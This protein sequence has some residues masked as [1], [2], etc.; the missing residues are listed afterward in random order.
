MKRLTTLGLAFVLLCACDKETFFAGPNQYQDGFEDYASL[1]DLL[2]QNELLWSFNQLTRAGNSI[3]VD[4]T[5]AHE[6]RKSLKF[7]AGKSADGVV[8]K[9][10]VAK[11]NMAF[12]E[13]E[14]MRMSAWYFI[15]GRDSLNWLF[16]MDVEE[17]TP[18]GAGPGMRLALVENQLRVEYKFFEKDI[19]QIPE[20]MTEMPRNQW[21][22][23]V[24]EIKLSRKNKGTIKLWQNGK[25]IIDAQNKT[26][27][28]KDILYFQQGTKGMYS[29]FEIGITANSA[30]N[31]LQLW[32]DDV[33]IEK[34][35]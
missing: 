19:L 10:S 13:G 17:Q 20:Q 8:S 18:I 32:V 7:V 30:E 25:L 24:W 21:V 23:L 26:T 33:R 22:E 27:L 3:S 35:N 15:E 9:A 2:P 5:K 29:S 31:D 34:L 16:L 14:T 11:Q 4:S 1:I 6:G 28:P 12:W